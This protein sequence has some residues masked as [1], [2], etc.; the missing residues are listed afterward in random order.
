MG[1][2]SLVPHQYPA[3]DKLIFFI[4]KNSTMNTS[5]FQTTT[6][7]NQPTR[8][9]SKKGIIVV[10]AIACLASWGYLLVNNKKTG[11]V[12]EQSQTQIARISDE[13]GN[14][15]KSFDESL[16][17][18]DSMA[19]ISNGLKSKL[20]AENK[21]IARRKAEIRVILN[22]KNATSSELAKAKELITQLNDKIGS[23]EQEV[24]RLTN[25]NQSLSQDK[26]V[27]TQEKGKLTDDL[28]AT[29]V[30][31]EDLEKKV[32]IASTLNASNIMITPVN[33]KS[34][35][36]EKVTST[37]KRVNK[38]VI[39]FDVNNRIAQTGTADIYVCVAGPDGK[40]IA[41]KDAVSNTFTTR[42]EGDRAYTAKLPVELETGKKK[43]VE[44]SFAPGTD[45]QQGKYLIQIYQNGFKIGEGVRELKKGGLFS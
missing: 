18:L 14:V 1:I 45:F 32:D 42:D 31:K 2:N 27:L 9:N 36:K 28:S 44:F 6:S 16:I 11:N 25:D 5:N 40:N 34:N 8:K 15:Q 22:K 17:R 37:A 10:L 41:T 21:E 19:S 43:N 20:T 26:I 30:V 39:S 33:V 4:Y 38:L 13:K 3:W 23:M 12:I 29:M 7:D 35:G 24:T